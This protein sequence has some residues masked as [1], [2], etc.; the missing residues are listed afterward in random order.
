MNIFRTIGGR[1][2]VTGTERID[3]DGRMEVLKQDEVEV[4]PAERIRWY[5]KAKI[6][7]RGNTP[8]EI[9]DV[10]KGDTNGNDMAVDVKNRTMLPRKHQFSTEARLSEQRGEKPEFHKSDASLD[11]AVGVMT[12]AIIPDLPDRKVFDEAGKTTTPDKQKKKDNPVS[13]ETEASSSAKMTK[14]SKKFKMA[15]AFEQISKIAMSDP[16]SEIKLSSSQVIDISD[17]SGVSV[18]DVFLL[19][20]VAQSNPALAGDY[21]VVRDGIPPRRK[22]RNR[23]V[24]NEVPGTDPKPG[25]FDKESD[26]DEQENLKATALKVG[27]IP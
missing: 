15:R 13:S 7:T 2:N 11:N 3:R 12:G 9:Y 5:N 18:E 24:S 23:P 25:G 8:E 19:E 6:D 16:S 10:E 22:R 21:A 27:L 1:V 20:R 14:D 4:T 17:E 26:E